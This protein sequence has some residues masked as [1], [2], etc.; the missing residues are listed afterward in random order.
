MEEGSVHR[1]RIDWILLIVVLLTS[2]IWCAVADDAEAA[3]VWR[4]LALRVEF[5]K[6]E[7]DHPTTTGDGTF[8]LRSL[9][10]ARDTYVLPYDTP[11][12]DR[13]YFEFHLEALANYYRAVSDGRVAI[14]FDVFPREDRGSYRLP[15]DMVYYGS[16]RTSDIQ[17]RRLVELFRDSIVAADTTEGDD[18]R[19]SA[20]RSFLVIH[21]G[22]GK[23]T[24]GLNDIPSAYLSS[25]D[26]RTHL[27]DEVS[28][29][30]GAYSVQDGW[31]LPEAIS[32]QGRGG[33]NGLMAKMFGHQLGLPVWSNLDDGLPALGGWSLMDV[34]A[35]NRGAGGAGFV[36]CHPMAWSK[37]HLGWI[38]PVV[39][40]RDT[41]VQI[42]A[43]HISTALPRAV[44]VPVHSHE[45]FL[46]ENREAHYEGEGLPSGVRLSG[47]STGVWLSV[48][49]YDAFIP[50]SGILIWHVD[51]QVIEEKWTDNR[52][53]SDPLHRGID[54]EEADGYEDIG[55]GRRMW[56]GGEIEG[57]PKDPFY[58]GNRTVFSPE[59]VPGSETYLGVRTGV[60][61]EVLSPPQ[62][63]MSV[64]ISF[65][66]HV[67]GWPVDVDADMEQ[68]PPIVADLDGDGRAEVIALSDLGDV[69]VWQGDGTPI[70]GAG[71]VF[72]SLGDSAAGRPVV[73]D[74]DGDGL[75]EVGVASVRGRVAF[76]TPKDRDG[77]GFAD[78]WGA[79]ELGVRLTAGPLILGNWDGPKVAA[80]DAK[81]RVIFLSPVSGD[82]RSQRVVSGKAIKK[83]VSMDID[84][85][86]NVDL[87]GVVEE[88]T[89]FTFQG[90][91]ERL[92]WNG[93]G[94][95]VGLAAG[96][97]D[98]DGQPEIVVAF[99]HGRV[100]ALSVNEEAAE[101]KF[102]GDVGG[103]ISSD[104]A[105]GDLDRDGYLEIVAGGIGRMYAWR[106]NRI[107]MSNFPAMLPVKD[108]VGPITSAPVLVD[109][110]GDGRLDLLFGSRAD[111]VM[112]ISSMGVP[113]VGFPWAALGPISSSLVV[114]DVN[115]D[116]QLELGAVTASGQVQVWALEAS[117]DREATTWPMAGRDLWNT[118]AY[119]PSSEA[120]PTGGEEWFPTGAYCYPNPVTGDRAA[121]RFYLGQAAEV[122]VRLFNGAG[123]L[124]RKWTECRT[125]ARSEQEIPWDVGNL[126]S[127][128]Y[129]CRLEGNAGGQR[130]TIFVKVAIVR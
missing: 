126:E 41:T 58:E 109:A 121:F 65:D 9:E 10:E 106:A 39:V 104:I 125:L 72:A 87:I 66:R 42:V 52:I 98:V 84:Q 27:G 48:D 22:V 71:S 124:V 18:L 49:H 28:V 100:A 80:G 17:D 40:R 85:N 36:P 81:G 110:D 122:E 1:V 2:V 93:G 16:G 123:E 26:L 113:L 44:K 12:H 45:Y 54:L 56:E 95:P 51:E 73:V 15:R 129:L 55:N 91:R 105:L 38:E 29:D 57:G 68:H 30:G 116:D 78:L 101:M 21:A 37:I 128:L 47:D 75:K 13:R 64:R 127:G 19:F 62:D 83:L 4:I 23:E 77:D 103:E 96:D 70:L 8:D 59:T 11:P 79:F 34:G 88:G 20:Y 32:F 60:R 92:L 53:N 31:I 99:A 107:P 74:L 46:L 120:Q 86:G 43:T 6:E 108:R 97:I 117:V 115:R 33:L 14:S 24:G 119:P 7:P 76:W 112:A 90:E 82:V 35:F 94:H 5:P 102:D 114:G 61:I 118:S 89:V 69:Y 50:G 111:Q 25:Q 3:D 67:P 63:T 130:K